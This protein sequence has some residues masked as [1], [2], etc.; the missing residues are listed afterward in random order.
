MNVFLTDQNK[1]KVVE[2]VARI[3][4]NSTSNLKCGMTVVILVNSKLNCFW[5]DM[6]LVEE[7]PFLGIHEGIHIDRGWLFLIVDDFD[8]GVRQF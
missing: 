1:E 5:R 6:D 3:S 2:V 7:F 8:V 4:S